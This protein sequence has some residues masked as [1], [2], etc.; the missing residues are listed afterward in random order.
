MI[1][2]KKRL[3]IEPRLVS[4]GGRENHDKEQ[5]NDTGAKVGLQIYKWVG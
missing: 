3:N 2:A 1:V 4:I 5:F